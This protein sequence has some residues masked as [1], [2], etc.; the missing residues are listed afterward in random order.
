MPEAYF[1]QAEQIEN[2]AMN[3][4]A[5]QESAVQ[6]LFD[7]KGTMDD[8]TMY[9]MEILMANAA[10]GSLDGWADVLRSGKYT[11]DSLEECC[12]VWADM[13]LRDFMNCAPELLLQVA[14]DSQQLGQAVDAMAY[15]TGAIEEMAVMMEAGEFWYFW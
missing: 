14:G 11:G 2:E 15:Y 13:I 4:Q 8:E 9:N 5:A 1:A 6:K 3:N 12:G 10:M 7:Y